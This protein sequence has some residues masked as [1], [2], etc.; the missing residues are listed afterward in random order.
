MAFL[1]GGAALRARNPVRA[2]EGVIRRSLLP[3]LLEVRRHNQ[4]QG[5]DDLALFEVSALAFDAPEA[6]PKQLQAAGMLADR[7]FRDL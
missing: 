6:V 2:R 5:N 4:D 1:D 3:S 7:P